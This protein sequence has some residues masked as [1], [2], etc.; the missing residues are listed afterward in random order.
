VRAALNDAADGPQLTLYGPPIDWTVPAPEVFQPE[1]ITLTATRT[2]VRCPGGARAR[3]RQRPKG[4]QGWRF[5]FAPAQCQ[6]CPLRAQCLQ[7]STQRGRSVTKNDYEAQSPAAQR[8]AQ[9]AED[10]AVRREHPRMERKL[11]ALM[12]W[13]NGRR[14]RYRGRLR[15][16]VQDWLTALVVNCNR[17]VTLLP[18][19]LQPKLA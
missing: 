1:V 8:R 14:V 9:T 11:A 17:L 4:G 12:R 3:T 16:K 6:P 7:P 19:P 18:L 2:E 15:V 10:R 13:Q 5:S